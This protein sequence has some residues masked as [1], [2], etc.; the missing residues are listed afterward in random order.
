M[1][2]VQKNTKF[3]FFGLKRILV[4]DCWPHK[5]WVS[6]S[7]KHFCKYVLENQRLFF[8]KFLFNIP[9]G[10]RWVLVEFGFFNNLCMVFSLFS[11]FVSTVFLEGY[12]PKN[13]LEQALGNISPLNTLS[14]PYILLW[15]Q[16]VD[17]VRLR[18]DFSL[19][20]GPF[21]PPDGIWRADRVSLN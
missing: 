9:F 21:L 2:L 10:C 6:H 19:L 4:H 15:K 18:R 14:L 8:L 7:V 13:S 3:Q 12:K 17:I 1:L 16:N 11:S 5:K 20:L